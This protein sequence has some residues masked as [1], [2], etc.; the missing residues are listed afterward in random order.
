VDAGLGVEILE[1]T[2]VLVWWGHVAHDAVPDDVVERVCDRVYRGMG[3]V[4]LHSGH[5]SKVFKRLMGTSCNLRWRNVGEREIVWNVAP[6]HPITSGVPEFFVL[7]QQEMYGEVFD[8]PPPEETIFISGF[9]G[10]EVFRS[11]CCFT[12]GRGRIFYF[13]PGDQEYPVY[14]HPAVQRVLT[15]GV[16]WAW[17]EGGISEDAM[18]LE[19]KP[20]AWFEKEGV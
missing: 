1:Q 4:M 14:H 9:A 15:N 16:R 8:I 12:R 19:E 13:S 6:G 10:G 2:D 18:E 3:L 17:S 11:G 7:E 5:W 20:W